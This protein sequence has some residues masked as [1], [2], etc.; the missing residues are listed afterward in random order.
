MQ[1]GSREG[2]VRCDG[3]ERIGL[4]TK[5]APNSIT[6]L[7]TFQESSHGCL[8]HKHDNAILV[9]MTISVAF[10]EQIFDS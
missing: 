5:A 4:Y 7:E 8:T 10:H 1:G 6:C 2:P 3:A 9:H